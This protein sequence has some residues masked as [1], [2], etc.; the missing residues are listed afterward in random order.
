MNVR[1]AVELGR[2]AEKL[3]LPSKKTEVTVQHS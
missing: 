1:T 2:I 3:N